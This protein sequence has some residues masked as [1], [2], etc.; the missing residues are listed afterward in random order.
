MTTELKPEAGEPQTQP[1]VTLCPGD[2][3]GGVLGKDEGLDNPPDRCDLSRHVSEQL[4]TGRSR[5]VTRPSRQVA[6]WGKGEFP[7]DLALVARSGDRH[8][9]LPDARLTMA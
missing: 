6:C 1:E 9:V 4:H 5:A 7:P 3:A 2:R 8:R